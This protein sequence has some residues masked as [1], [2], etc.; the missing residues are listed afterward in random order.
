[1][2]CVTDSFLKLA[3]YCEIPHFTGS[4]VT[5]CVCARER[6]SI[7][8]LMLSPSICATKSYDK[9]S[10]S[11]S[12]IHLNAMKMSVE[13]KHFNICPTLQRKSRYLLIIPMTI[14]K[15]C[16]FNWC[17]LKRKII[18]L[19]HIRWPCHVCLYLRLCLR[20]FVVLFQLWLLCLSFNYETFVRCVNSRPFCTIRF[21]ILAMSDNQFWLQWWL[22]V[23]ANE[24]M[25]RKIQE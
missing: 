14:I 13:G 17:H 21:F 19:N 25:Y 8:F 7:C 2:V 15:T 11:V 1:M 18:Q 23:V 16:A 4:I 12:Q 6:A 5:L 24:T 20:A 10:Q 3:D 9:R 22:C